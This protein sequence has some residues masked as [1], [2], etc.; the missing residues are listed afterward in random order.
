MLAVQC[1]SLSMRA[2]WRGLGN[3]CRQTENWQL[4]GFLVHLLR[5]AAACPCAGCMGWPQ[6]RAADTASGTSQG[7]CCRRKAWKEF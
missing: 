6:P 1:S 5:D 3:P 2:G 7:S 4:V